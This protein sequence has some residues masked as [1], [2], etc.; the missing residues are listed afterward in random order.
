MLNSRFPISSRRVTFD[1]QPIEEVRAT[2]GEDMALMYEWFN[3]VGYDVD[4]DDLD[5]T[6]SR[7]RPQPV[8]EKSDASA[9]VPRP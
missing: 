7:C 8:C 2:F 6:R 1:E 9:A 4:I 5:S 3:E